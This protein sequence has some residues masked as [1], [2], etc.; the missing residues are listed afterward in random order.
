MKDSFNCCSPD[1]GIISLLGP[2]DTCLLPSIHWGSFS[3]TFCSS[4]NLR[5][6]K[7]CSQIYA[8][9]RILV[10]FKPFP[11]SCLSLISST[12]SEARG[13]LARTWAHIHTLFKSFLQLLGLSPQSASCSPR[14]G[15]NCVCLTSYGPCDSEHQSFSQPPTQEVSSTPSCAQAGPLPGKPCCCS[16]LFLNLSSVLNFPGNLCWAEFPRHIHPMLSCG[17][18]PSLEYLTVLTSH[19]VSQCFQSTGSHL[20]SRSPS[21][22]SLL[23]LKTIHLHTGTSGH[24]WTLSN[25]NVHQEYYSID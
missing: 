2:I 18:G 7:G 10:I 17:R 21:H 1:T 14:P 24:Y 16:G 13:I 9:P 15:P 6:C 23:F 11:K 12:H 22:S 25:L 20:D 5:V 8:T 3:S 19:L 4:S